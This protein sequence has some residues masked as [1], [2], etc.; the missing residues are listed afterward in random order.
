METGRARIDPRDI[1]SLNPV[2]LAE[3]DPAPPASVKDVLYLCDG[4]RTVLQVMAECSLKP[5]TG[6]RV[7]SRALEMGLVRK[8]GRPTPAIVDAITTLPGMG[9]VCF[10]SALATTLGAPSP[11]SADA[12]QTR[13][14]VRN[15]DRDVR[16]RRSQGFEDFDEA[17]F[18]SYAPE[19]PLTRQDLVEMGAIKPRR[20]AAPG[21]R[22]SRQSG[23]AASKGQTNW[24]NRMAGWIAGFLSL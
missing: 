15:R 4:K 10:A 14:R 11:A 16:V 21:R 18:E 17:F 24:T 12:V 8:T 7:V 20:R 2:A 22:A 6:M 5:E 23:R 1:V 3:A 19:E 13:N 9:E